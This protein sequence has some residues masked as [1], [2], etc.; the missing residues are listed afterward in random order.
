M[1]VLSRK[2]DTSV[3]IGSNVEVQV[4]SIRGR[5]KP[6]ATRLANWSVRNPRSRTSTRISLYGK[7]R[8]PKEPGDEGHQYSR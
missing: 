6:S 5:W 3:R 7:G 8:F 4:L 1:L 2:P